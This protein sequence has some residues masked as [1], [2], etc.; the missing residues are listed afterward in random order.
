MLATIALARDGNSIQ[1]RLKLRHIRVRELS[2]LAVL[3]DASLVLGAGN[4]DATLSHD[5]ADSDLGRGDALALGDLVDGIDELDVLAEVLGLETRQ[6]AAEVVLGEV[7]EA[8]ECASQPAAA[9]GA[10]RCDG[11]ADC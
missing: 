10:V 11:Y 4:G 6:L 7:V 1:D 2:R 8:A 3:N 5:P 9:D